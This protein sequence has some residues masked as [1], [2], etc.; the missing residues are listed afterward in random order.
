MRPA[1]IFLCSI[2]FALTGCGQPPDPN[3]AQQDP[4]AAEC[5]RQ[6]THIVT[7]QGNYVE[8]SHT[9]IDQD[10]LNA[11]LASHGLRQMLN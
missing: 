8:T 10:K 2:M 5:Q 3:S 6:N 7:T 9:V 1:L 4:A 11:C